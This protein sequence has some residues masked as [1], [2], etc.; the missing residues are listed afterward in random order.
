MQPPGADVVVVRVGEI[1]TKSDQVRG[2]M[3]RR[4]RNNVAALL[5]ERGIDATIEVRRY[6]LILHAS[7]TEAARDAATDAFGVVS[8]SPARRVDPTIDAISDA[9]AA[10]AREYYDGGT[11]AVTARRAGE[12]EDHPF[13]SHDIQREAGSAVWTAA[14]DRG[15]DPEVDLDDP[16]FEL[17]VECRPDV[18]YVFLEKRSGPGGL[19]LGTQDPVVA[20]ISGGHDSP[21]AAWELMKRGAPVVPLYVDLGDYGGADHQARAAATVADL[22]RYAPNQDMRLRVAPA[23]PVVDDIATAVES[24][25][26]LVLRRFMFRVAE[27]VAREHEAVG[28]VTGEAIGQKSSQTTANLAATS[29]ATDLPVHRPL[30]TRDKDAITEQADAIGTFAESSIPAGC[31][32][33]APE[34]PET[35]GD[36]ASVA[37]LEF[38]DIAERAAMV[39]DRVRVVDHAHDPADGPGEGETA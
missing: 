2:K 7:D 24:G 26:M 25:R 6:R 18:A 33:L 20:L 10:C 12:A 16:D 11:F 38:D 8:A 36:P 17:F 19:P 1:G 4:L 22:A 27:R 23:G 35:R 3:V 5:E 39:A 13:T 21:V 30:V 9:L 37:T 34:Y 14:E 32:R 31:H 15:L 29:T 28:I